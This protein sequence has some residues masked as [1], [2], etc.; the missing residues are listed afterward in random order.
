M[1]HSLH[2]FIGED[3][4]PIAEAIDNHL[5]QHCD[6]EG[7]QF[8]HVATWVFEGE[9]SIVRQIDVRESKTIISNRIEGVAYFENKH[10]HIVVAE[11][12]GEVSSNLYVCVYLLLY[13]ETALKE[14]CKILE[15]IKISGKH[16]LV[17]VYGISEDLAYLFCVSEAEKHDLVY[18]ASEM[19]Q[20]AAEA[21]KHIIEKEKDDSIR[22]FLLIQGCN[23]NGLGLD[24]DKTTL[25]RIFGEYARLV[26]TNY[27][28][29]YPVAD[30]DK[31]DVL[32]LG[33]SAYWF[34]HKFFH[35]YIF[36]CCFIRVLERERVNQHAML[37]PNELLAKAQE[38]INRYYSLLSN[39]RGEID[40]SDKIVALEEFDK[41]LNEATNDFHG[42]I[43][44]TD[45]SLPE[46]RAMLALLMGEDDELFDDSV[47][48]K[49]LPTIDDC[50]T[51]AF[52]L[53]INENNTMVEEGV[54]GVLAGPIRG[55]KIYLPLEEL[56]KQRTRIRQSQSFIRKGEERLIEIEKGIKIA[57]ESKKRLTEEGFVYGDVTY[58]LIHNI[59]EKPLEETYNPQRDHL[60]SV[61]LRQSFS[62]IRNQGKLGSCT[63]FSVASI[64]EYILNE[65][66]VGKK[67]CLSPRFLYYNV[68][69][70]NSDNTPIDK[71]SSFYDN[72]HSLGERGICEENLCP[73]DDDFK[74]S[75]TEEATRDAITRLVTKALNVDVTHDA[76]TSALSEGYPI[77]ISL[78]VFDS[79]AKGHKGFI[80]RPTDKE[81]KSSD[82]GY[83]AMVICGYSEIDKVYIVRNSWGEGFGDKGYCYVP[84]SY[85][86][87]K[88]L[89]RQACII[90]G[91]S[92]KEIG[93]TTKKSLAFDIEDK[94]IEYAVLRIL[95]EEEKVQQQ[96]YVD[97]Y[98]ETYKG[99]MRLLGEL[100]NKGK[101]DSI[102]NYALRQIKPSTQTELI[103]EEK[104][105][106]TYKSH[107]IALGL[108]L[109]LLCFFLLPSNDR[110]IGVAVTI[111][112]TALIWWKYPST[113][114]IV[115]KKEVAKTMES[116]DL[117]N[118][119]IQY[120]YAGRII[121]RFNELRNVL[122]NKRKYLQS[123]ISNL[124]TWLNEEKIVLDGMDEHMRKPF[125]SLFS[126][127]Q[128][129]H[130]ISENYNFFI[131]DIWLYKL[132]DG[133]EVTDKAIVD[134]KTLLIHEIEH[135]LEMVCNDFT[136]SRYLLNLIECEYL[137]NY[138]A[139][140]IL[141]TIL[142]M[143]IPF[144]QANGIPPR[145]DKILFC[146]VVAEDSNLWDKLIQSNY[147]AVPKLTND[148]STQKITYVQFQK[149]KLEETIYDERNLRQ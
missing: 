27:S 146:N 35:R 13:E 17:D 52:N 23:L 101:R 144:T 16:Y 125:Y 36:S 84:F 12:T 140:E 60:P 92:C 74:T 108:V 139:D 66:S 41:L 126:D 29:L 85:I 63:S 1:Q 134:F 70:K 9:N 114:I 64:F 79:F 77:G 81:L 69:D 6:C 24:L 102:M 120:L 22:H 55:G 14:L 46:K 18:K 142:N 136:M 141:R 112:A 51:E 103:E 34:S 4:A 65:G 118:Q 67:S 124:E 90:T 50:M 93:E 132:F 91:V 72:I 26:T 87:D 104:E 95:I 86:E 59:V 5:T 119:E 121:D 130:Y 40:S 71:G 100:S 122:S 45:L 48:L 20:K 82:F 110:L 62:V 138:K 133:F 123:Y 32:A 116:P 11:G 147:T 117:H 135:R 111:V 115:I 109:T 7:R 145:T 94:D 127:V 15:W 80:F 42:V 78:K 89:C 149:Y 54:D 31:P 61:D 47:L 8:S 143:S 44:R 97:G 43:E 73:Y 83:H 38:Y 106:P 148:T 98:N 137:P 10:P 21:C 56:R 113:K 105:A 53:F 33:I 57:E 19:K 2:I 99:Y 128:A 131:S 28:D 3:L 30:I 96:S 68:C 88:Q 37:S 107:Y 39:N 129:D 75:P 49:D 76:L 25:I 58:K